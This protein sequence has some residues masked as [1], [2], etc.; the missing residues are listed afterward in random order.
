MAT[1]NGGPESDQEISGIEIEGGDP[2]MRREIVG[3]MQR[4]RARGAPLRSGHG[5][6]LNPNSDVSIRQQQAP[7]P[8]TSIT[9]GASSTITILPQRTFKLTRLILVDQTDFL[10]SL[11]SISAFVVGA[12]NQLINQGNSPLQA[13]AFSAV[14]AGLTGNTAGPGRQLSL[15]LVNGASGTRVIAGVFFG[16]AA[17]GT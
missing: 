3:A 15:T 1:G 17:D 11:C 9:A 4:A 10:N 7:L 16:P 8:L 13:Y 6:V 2:Q 12:E 5:H 14:G